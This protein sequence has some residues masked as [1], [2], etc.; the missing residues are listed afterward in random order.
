[1]DV[2]R[3]NE[4]EQREAKNFILLGNKNDFT[5]SKSDNKKCLR[6]T[7]DDSSLDRKSMS[8]SK[9]ACP[10]IRSASTGRD[11]RSEFHARYWAF[12][13]GNLQRAVDEIYKTVEYYENV[14]SCQEAILVLEN[15]IREFRAL[16]NYFKMSWDYEKT[17]KKPQSIAWEVRKTNSMPR[18]RNRTI[19]SSPAISGKSSPSYSGTNSPC[20]T[21]EEHKP[22]ENHVSKIVNSK[23]SEIDDKEKKFEQLVVSLNESTT[24]DELQDMKPKSISLENLSND[25][26][27][28]KLVIKVDGNTQTE[29]MEDDNLTL[30]EFMTKHKPEEKIEI[31]EIKEEEKK[32][33]EP[34]KVKETPKIE[35]KKPIETPSLS[36]IVNKPTTE[37]AKSLT[38][39]KTQSRTVKANYSLRNQTITSKNTQRVPRKTT[40][41]NTQQTKK[42]IPSTTPAAQKSLIG[43]R[44]K[45][46]IEIS[47]PQGQNL[48]PLRRKKSN[49]NNTDSSSSTSTL[50]AS[51]EKLN[52]KNSL[53]S[54]TFKS[55]DSKASGDGEWFTVKT[56]RRS[57]WTSRFDQ[58]SSYAS[59][60]ALALL[61]ENSEDSDKEQV[62]KKEPP[63]VEKKQVPKS[64]TVVSKPK[65]ST[66]TKQSTQQQ[67]KTVDRKPITAVKSAPKRATLMES[68]AK[69][70]KQQPPQPKQTQPINQN[71]I[72]RQKSDI[73][74]LKIKS[75]HKEYLRN[76]RAGPKKKKEDSSETKVDMNLQTT[77][78]LISQTIHELYSE[79]ENSKKNSQFSNGN[80]SSC[81]EIEERDLESDDD[82]KKLVEEQESLERQI[83]E[84]ENSEIDVDT[85]TDETDCEAILCDL[86]DNENSENNDRNSPK[87]EFLNDENISLEMRYAPMLAEMTINEREETL[88]TLQELVARDPGRAQKLHQK[89]SSPSRRRS[90][91]E[92]IKKYQAKHT[93]ALEKRTV[94][95]Q[96]KTLKLQQLIQRVEQVKAAR[97]QL[98][99]NRRLRMEEKLQ[100]AAENRENFLKNKVKKAHDE[101]EKLKEIAFIKNLEMQNKRLDF[102]ESCKE[103]EVRRQDLEQE[104]QKRQT[105]KLAKEAAVERRRLEIE[106][107]RKKKLEKMD[108]TRREREQRVEKIQEEKEKLRQEMAKEKQRDRDK[109][110]QAIQQQQL[111][112]TE[113]LQRKITRKQEEYQKRHEEN[114]EHIR[115]RAFE[116]TQ[117]RN[118][119]DSK[120]QND[121]EENVENIERTREA[122]RNSKKKMKKIKERFNTLNQSYLEELPELAA[123]H[124]KQSQIPKLI[125]AIKKSNQNNS[126]KNQLGAERPIGQIIR[127]IEKSTVVDFHCLWLLDGLGVLATIIENG[128]QPNSDISR[129]AVIKAIQLYRNACSS[130]KQIAHHSILAGSF[131]TLLDALNFALRNPEIEI[132]TSTCPVEV[133]TELFLALTVVLSNLKLTANDKNIALEQRINLL[134]KYITASGLLE[135]VTKKCLKVREP[136]ENQQNL[137]LPLLSMIGF[138]T[139]VTEVCSYEKSDF[140]ATVVSTEIFGMINL[141]YK[142]MSFGDAIPKRTISLAGS[143]YGLIKAIALL[144]SSCLQKVLNQDKLIFKFL[145]VVTI[146]LNY[147]GPKLCE[148]D[149][150]EMKAMIRDLVIILGY[151]SANNRRNQNLLTSEQSCIILKSITKLPI[152]LAPVYYPTLLTIIWENPEAEEKLAKDFDIQMLKEYEKSS[153]AKKNLLLQTLE[154]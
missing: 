89:L 128:L 147:C 10:R 134:L 14:E 93:R 144:D 116:L 135:I 75:L 3:A 115:Q 61:N 142:T 63:K 80:L 44:S 101:E 132:K 57:S 6:K 64:K 32:T 13:F 38:A 29:G 83:R 149:D 111:Q 140:L 84:L 59:L 51:V 36:Q 154:I 145:D 117:Q 99:E 125:N 118:I 100:R 95:Q 113:E 62:T 21:I 18:V 5:L 133:S 112:D 96:Q 108:E 137:L 47:K 87:D 55:A 74:G 139:K 76:E 105:E 73:T 70:S 104:R 25:I 50:K 33:P 131:I 141:L 150:K 30:Q 98:I 143:T 45:T 129:I 130:C 60:P 16:A 27:V 35:T 86:D 91:R 58:P 53:K 12:L 37:A 88:A 122:I 123:V 69:K 114:I 4:F 71:L 49:E 22:V 102:I 43:N 67:N 121:E 103:Q 66:V 40:T 54:L 9:N 11:K 146:L 26:E 153:V 20:P 78:V 39:Q 79:I 90:V 85:E 81:D 41:V 2:K 31:P 92:T 136:I 56:K 1:M 65:V 127:I 68:N 152:D 138:V 19:N 77:Q 106:L 24:N 15:Y 7:S 48:V 17:P 94:I 42:I 148:N 119:D 109:R 72:K 126:G 120:S 8:M 151:F 34:Q 46:M 107:E 110:L 82:Q 52:S 97:E 28:K 124:K 23:K